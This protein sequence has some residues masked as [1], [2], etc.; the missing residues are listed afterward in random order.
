MQ[1]PIH[2]R[3]KLGFAAMP[4]FL[5]IIL[6]LALL[7]KCGIIDASKKPHTPTEQRHKK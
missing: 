1:P 6:L 5:G 7:D 2:P 3:I 4:F